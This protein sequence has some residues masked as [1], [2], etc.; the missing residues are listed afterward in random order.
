MTLIGSAIIVASGIYTVW[1]ERHL[2]QI[3]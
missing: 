1:R 2:K 3:A